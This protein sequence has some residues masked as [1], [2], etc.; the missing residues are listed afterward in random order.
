MTPL[1]VLLAVAAAVAATGYG[2]RRAHL[3]DRGRA[4]AAASGNGSPRARRTDWRRAVLAELSHRSSHGTARRAGGQHRLE[5]A[6]T[7]SLSATEIL[8]AL[9]AEARGR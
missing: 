3:V 1:V 6:H 5:D 4:A 7:C 9:N 8:R 2:L